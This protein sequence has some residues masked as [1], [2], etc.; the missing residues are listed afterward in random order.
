MNKTNK[1]YLIDLECPECGKKFCA[2]EVQTICKDCNSPIFANYDLETLRD[3]VTKQEIRQRPKG[4][5]RWAE[6]L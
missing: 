6:L 4:I 1:S 2:D 5:W 3:N